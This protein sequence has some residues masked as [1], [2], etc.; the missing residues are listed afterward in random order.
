[1]GALA[2]PSLSTL[3]SGGVTSLWQRRVGAL[4]LPSLS[5]LGSGGDESA[6]ATCG[7]ARTPVAVHV[8]IWRCWVWQRLVGALALLSLANIQFKAIVPSGFC[9]CFCADTDT[10]D[11]LK[12]YS[13]T[14]DDFFLSVDIRYAREPYQSHCPRPAGE[15]LAR[16]KSFFWQILIWLSQCATNAPSRHPLQRVLHQESRFDFI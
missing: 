16:I 4:T 15:S 10:D 6:A 7:C 12:G 11:G 14:A 1:M 5:T 3:G 8:W 13:L 2:P 9:F